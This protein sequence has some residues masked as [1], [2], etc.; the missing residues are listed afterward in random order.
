[1][2][3]T[4]TGMITET[5]PDSLKLIIAEQFLKALTNN[6]WDLLRNV[7]T[8][9]VSWT[10]PG[11]SIISGKVTGAT[12]V[13]KIAKILLGFG[14]TLKLNHYMIALQGVAISLHAE[15]ERNGLKLDQPLTFV[16]SISNG[17]ITAI[18]T[19]ISI[20]SQVNSLFTTQNMDLRETVIITNNEPEPKTNDENQKFAL[21]NVFVNALKSNDWDTM[22]SIMFENLTWTL[23]GTSILSGPAY[24]VNAVVKRARSLKQF[25]VMFQL[26][27][28]LYG[29]HGFTLLLHNTA[30][31][32]ELI[33]DEYVAIVFDVR[34]GKIAAMTTHLSDVKGIEQ[35]FVHGIID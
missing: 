3:T 10:L 2:E 8:E 7:I 28:I 6:D 9:D 14:V 34:D 27:H 22:R 15:V 31:R 20:T 33:L 5:T 4:N 18:N 24:G 19:S 1:M 23:P 30:K 29:M 26:Q 35:F 17:K 16:C 11:N 13:V 12:T 21:A 25:G 32:N